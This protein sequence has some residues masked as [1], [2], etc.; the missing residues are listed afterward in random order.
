MR[1]RCCN[2]AA[3]A[4]TAHRAS[5]ARGRSARPL[6]CRPSQGVSLSR[7]A[8]W[9]RE[10]QAT[11]VV[12]PRWSTSR[13]QQHR[14]GLCSGQ[15]K[16]VPDVSTSLLSNLPPI[17]RQKLAQLSGCFSPRMWHKD[18]QSAAK[19]QPV[20]GTRAGGVC[21]AA[22]RS[23][24]ALHSRRGCRDAAPAG[25]PGC[26]GASAGRQLSLRRYETQP[27]PSQREGQSP[28]CPNQ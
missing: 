2:T 18:K 6:S 14:E 12:S 19:A 28:V 1:Q 16:S 20:T 10:H 26:P 5:A 15:S 22:A 24:T 27:F 21:S 13:P 25:R 8:W 11:L 3:P 7:S 4:Y 23:G 9:G 17:S